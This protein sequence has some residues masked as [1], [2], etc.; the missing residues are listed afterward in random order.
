MRELRDVL[1]ISVGISYPID[2][3]CCRE[4]ER[5][6]VKYVPPEKLTL[7]QFRDEVFTKDRYSNYWSF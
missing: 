6:G 2:R 7:P 1:W 5:H 3:V 4:H